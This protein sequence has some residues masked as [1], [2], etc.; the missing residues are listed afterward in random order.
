MLGR[1]I[2]D[3]VGNR[4]GRLTV[5]SKAGADK[6]RRI[7]WLCQCECGKTVIV[8]GGSLQSGGTQSCGCLRNERVREAISL[9]IGEASFNDLVNNMKR[10]AKRRGYIWDLTNDQIKI[11]TSQLC[12]YCGVKPSQ[13]GTGRPFYNG[14]YLYNGIDRV[15][16][17]RG[18][19]MDNVVPCCG[20]CNRAKLTMP[21]EE[22][23]AWICRTYEHFGSKA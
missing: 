5:L 17:T 19:T 10:G 23:K 15:D 20:V 7:M 21:I 13:R 2:I 14:E 3:R 18:Y 9:P 16:N 4:Y 8:R 6:H 12:F 11:L 22:F 1:P